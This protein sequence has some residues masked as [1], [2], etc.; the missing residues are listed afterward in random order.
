MDINLALKDVINYI[1]ENVCDTIDYEKA[2]KI[3]GTSVFHFQRIFSFLTGIPVSEY[4]RRRKMTL[5]AFDL[6]QSDV[7]IIDIALKYGYETHS[8]FTRAFQQFHGVTPASVRSKGIDIQAYPPIQ[9]N[10]AIR[11][12]EAIKFRVEKTEPYKLFGREDIV[13]PM[14]H[15]YA[16]DFIKKYGIRVVEE[17]IHDSINRAAGFPAGDG[18]PFHLL[19]GIYFK[20]SDDTTRF[21]YG[22]ELP[23]DGVPEFFTVVDVPETT[24]AVFAYY[25]EHMESLPKIWTYIYSSWLPTSGYKTEDNIIIEKEAWL[26][27]RQEKFYAEVWIPLKK[28]DLEAKI[29]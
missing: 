4:I 13:V 21:M 14:D 1:E 29:V 24:W 5:A 7:K 15:Q 6:Q 17:G 9:L 23:K 28:N 19:H 25:G 2:A 10:I 8:S 26:E 3:V 18:Y 27:K 22:W 16:L 12:T 11:G 20:N